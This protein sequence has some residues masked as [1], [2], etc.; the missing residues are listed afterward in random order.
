MDAGGGMAGIGSTVGSAFPD[1][2]TL[3]LGAV[4]CDY[5]AR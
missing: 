1:D 2:M 5:L 4:T 3:P